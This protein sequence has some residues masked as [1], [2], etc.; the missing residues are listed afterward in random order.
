VLAE[1]LSLL[2]CAP[3]RPAHATDKGEFLL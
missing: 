2:D 3:F 1:F